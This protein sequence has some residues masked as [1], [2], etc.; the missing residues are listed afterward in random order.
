MVLES[1]ASPLQ[2]EEDQFKVSIIGYDKIKKNL[3]EM[4]IKETIKNYLTNEIL[5]PNEAGSL[6]STTPLISSGLVDSITTLQ[7]VDFIEKEFKIEFQAHEV[8]RDNLDTLEAIEAF[9]KSKS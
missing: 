8:D 5:S 1:L 6:T 4:D 2:I 3:C 7:L 9:V